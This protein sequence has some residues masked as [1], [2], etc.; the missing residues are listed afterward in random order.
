MD[1][2][3]MQYNSEFDENEEKSTPIV[4][5]MEKERIFCM[6]ATPGGRIITAGDTSGDISFWDSRTGTKEYD[7]SGHTEAVLALVVVADLNALFSAGADST[8]RLWNLETL[9]NTMVFEGHR[10]FIVGLFAMRSETG[11]GL[12]SGS[13]DRTVKQWN[14]NSGAC[15]HTYKGHK[16]PVNAITATET[17]MISGSSDGIIKIWDLG[18]RR[19]IRTIEAHTD[20]IWCLIQLKD[21]R[22]ASG[23][24]DSSIKI[25]ENIFLNNNAV[26]LTA[27]HGK[28]RKLLSY[29]PILFS[30]GAD[31]VI[32]AWDTR[33]NNL[34]TT[35]KYH[36][37]QISGL[38]LHNNNLCSS[39]FDKNVCR[40][41]VQLLL[42]E[43]QPIVQFQQLSVA[44]D[45]DGDGGDK[46]EGVNYRRNQ[47]RVREKTPEDIV[48]L[49]KE[50]PINFVVDAL[51]F[52]VTS[53]RLMGEIIFYI[54]FLICF[55][56][57][58]MLA[59]PIED[60]YYMTQAISDVLVT[61]QLP[62]FKN[63]RT[64]TEVTTVA[65]FY[66]WMTLMVTELWR[67]RSD[68][69][70][71]SVQGQNIL[72]GAMRVRQQRATP[73]S[74][75]FNK[76]FFNMSVGGLPCY[77]AL[78]SQG[79]T[80]PFVCPQYSLCSN[81][82]TDNANAIAAALSTLGLTSA[83]FTFDPSAGLPYEGQVASY[84]DGG[85]AIDFNF[86]EP[87]QV[88]LD[89]IAAM[90]TLGYVDE[91]V[92]RLV[93]VAFY[94]YNPSIDVFVS[95]LM[96]LEVPYG[97]TWMPLART[98]GF[99][100][101]T[102]RHSGQLGFQVFFFFFVLGFIA[103]FIW[104]FVA[105]FRKGRTTSFILDAWNVIEFVNLLIFIVMYGYLYSWIIQ[106]RQLKLDDLL[107]E[108]AYSSILEKTNTYYQSMVWFNAVNT[109]LT[110]MK[111][112][113]YVRL[114]DRLNILTRTLSVAQQSLL[115]VL[116]LFVYV[117]FGFALTGNNLYGVAM[118][119]FRNISV[120]YVALLRALIG[121][122]D[123][124]AMTM[125]T[126][127]VTIFFFWAYMILGQFILL[128]FLV[129]VISDGFH[130]VSMTKSSIPLD[131]TIVKAFKDARYEFLPKVLRWKFLLLRHRATQTTI[132]A[133][134]LD[135][136]VDKRNKMVDED[137]AQR[138]D[139]DEVED[140]LMRKADFKAL[141]PKDDQ[142]LLKENETF[143][144]EVWKDM[145]WE[146]HHKQMAA[147]GQDEI[148]REAIVF[149][150]VEQALRGLSASFP[151]MEQ[152]KNRLQVQEAK[153]RP[154]AR[155]MGI[156]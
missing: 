55:V 34:V 93:D 155:S 77:G 153:L 5:W 122:V 53:S 116:V 23:S 94:V 43:K 112:L 90:E 144:D 123:Y 29:G 80:S 3:F 96:V 110:F 97:G 118:F 1:L 2:R 39:G 24:T 58:F 56:F 138:Q 31:A 46:N 142:E 51:D 117:V 28:V 120:S 63:P 65:W 18:S 13:D 62:S 133:N 141:V 83:G 113:K 136:L 108:T 57:V 60:G 19:C 22:F 72:V 21:G 20:S 124:T 107:A 17:N 99:E 135:E 129:A 30:A 102:T 86:S 70:F 139:Y 143:I 89:K 140:V 91:V 48:E 71:P 111:L 69:T 154:L 152:L 114:N 127:I 137:A 64:F 95:F 9:Q 12:F 106:S 82:T 79:D 67:D 130:E 148:E 150:E 73:N 76:H 125:E 45:Q 84:T 85:F 59:R 104:Q 52:K 87:L 8:V 74:C 68:L 38:T 88:Q 42:P 11:T 54:P 81:T 156:R 16:G 126:I 25:W 115:G 66:T 147:K 105:D 146:Y 10:G 15:V 50:L 92:T 40:W 131:Q 151:V 100:V 121:D 27:H 14:S 49:Y 75:S 103:L 134:T 109:V 41:D 37:K 149:E 33:T 44:K 101:F 35:L 6:A 47:K 119:N 26:T 78:D 61:Q 36:T 98:T 4:T 7:L 32:Y 128:N 132:V 145:A